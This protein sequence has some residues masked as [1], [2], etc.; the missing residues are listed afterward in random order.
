M[1]LTAAAAG[2]TIVAA[3]A[4]GEP[5]ADNITGNETAFDLEAAGFAF[6]CRITR[7]ESVGQRA[8]K[9]AVLILPGSLFSDVDGDYPSMNMRPHVYRDLARAVAAHG[10]TAMRMAKPGPGTGTRVIDPARAE[11]AGFASRIEIAAAALARLASE[12]N[13]RPLVVAGHSEGALVAFL[14][15]ASDSGAAIDGVVSLSGP[16]LPLLDIMRKQVAGM[17]PPGAAPNAAPDLS[18]FD[19]AVAAIRAGKPLDPALAKNPQTAMMASMGPRALAY[20]AEVDRIDPIAAI[21]RVPQ[22]MLLIQGGVDVSVSPEQ[23]DALAHARGARPTAVRK[24]PAL[25][26]FYKVAPP[27]L[28]P[29][30]NMML[31]T[32]SDPAV[33][34]A[35]AG[36]MSGLHGH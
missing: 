4:K 34:D 29:M 13:A 15:A 1:F 6:P 23:V 25:T 10:V 30:Q 20:I 24:F 3:R 21:A 31:D 27:G 32:D 16:A 33:A 8:S 35:I 5:M 18:A 7:P 2:A 22:P 12:E 36:W 17:A 9:G 28:P 14:L 26:H 19:E 11:T